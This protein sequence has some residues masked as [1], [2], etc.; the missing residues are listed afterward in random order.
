MSKEIEKFNAVIMGR[1]EWQQAK[2]EHIEDVKSRDEFWLAAALELVAMHHETGFELPD[3]VR[4]WMVDSLTKILKRKKPNEFFQVRSSQGPLNKNLTQLRQYVHLIVA[5]R[6][7]QSGGTTLL[8]AF[9][10]LA[11]IM[12]YSAETLQQKYKTDLK[13]TRHWFDRLSDEKKMELYKTCKFL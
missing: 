9:E 2:A 10:T 13:I 8:D 1:H 3:P 6:F 12:A 5:I 11:P 4:L 7:L